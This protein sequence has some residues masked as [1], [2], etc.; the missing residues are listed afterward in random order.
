MIASTSR[1]KNQGEKATMA[2]E[3][4]PYRRNVWKCKTPIECALALYAGREGFPHYVIDYDGTIYSVSPEDHEAWHAGWTVEAGGRARWTRWSPPASWSKV[5]GVGKTP[6]DLIPSDANSPNTRH[7]GIEL[8]GN[9][10]N[11]L[12]SDAQ[13]KALARLVV[14]I[15][16]RYGLDLAEPPNPRLLGHE[17]VNPLTG[18]G[19][20]ADAYGGWDPGAHRRNPRFSWSRL[21]NVMREARSG[22]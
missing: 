3:K 21:A 6:L 10:T 7:I 15:E 4:N 14:D 9:L 12:Y 5:W 1:T 16:R 18:K 20:R 17:D 13:Y 11:R 2:T 19:G 22:K 8:L